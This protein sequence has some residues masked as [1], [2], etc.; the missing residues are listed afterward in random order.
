M[1]D[2]LKCH[3]WPY[4]RTIMQVRAGPAALVT[5]LTAHSRPPHA[6]TLPPLP[7]HVRPSPETQR[8]PSPNPTANLQ[9]PTS[10]LLSQACEAIDDS[11][12]ATGALDGDT[13]ISRGSFRA[14]LAAAGAVCAAVDEVVSAKVRGRDG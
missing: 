9:P 5:L 6:A 13:A 7:P 1:T 3:E 2:V 10:N 4:L 8:S 11:P 14:A 12:S